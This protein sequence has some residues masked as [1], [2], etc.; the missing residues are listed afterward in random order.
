MPRYSH[1]PNQQM[2]VPSGRMARTS[3]TRR[4][5]PAVTPDEILDSGSA[6]T[7]WIAP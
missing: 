5:W 4:D 3:M 7:G 6:I 2:I 1:D